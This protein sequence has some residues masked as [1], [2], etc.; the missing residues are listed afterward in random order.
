M[1]IINILI[2]QLKSY[3]SWIFSFSYNHWKFSFYYRFF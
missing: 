2:N 1:K 3:S